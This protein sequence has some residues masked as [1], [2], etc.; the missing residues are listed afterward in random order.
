MSFLVSTKTRLKQK[1]YKN[2]KILNN[3][4]YYAKN[5]TPYGGSFEDYE[6]YEYIVKKNNENSYFFEILPGGQ[7]NHKKIDN[8]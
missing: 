3:L 5:K 1:L 2:P 7:D 6:D 4:S 8:N